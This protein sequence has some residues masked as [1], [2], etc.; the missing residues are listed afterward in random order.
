MAE[1]MVVIGVLAILLSIMLPIVGQGPLEK[2]REDSVHEQ[3]AAGVCR[4]SWRFAADHNRRRLPG[5][6]ADQADPDAGASRLVDM[7]DDA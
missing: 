7:A 3:P 4:A 1:L 5:S 6:I 2:G